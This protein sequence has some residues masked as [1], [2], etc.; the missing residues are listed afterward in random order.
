MSDRVNKQQIRKYFIVSTLLLVSC[1]GLGGFAIL[2]ASNFKQQMAQNA[3][4]KTTQKFQKIQFLVAFL[5][6]PN[7]YVRP[8]V[9]EGLSQILTK[10]DIPLLIP[11]L[12]DSDPLVYFGIMGILRRLLVREAIFIGGASLASLTLLVLLM[13]RYRVQGI[14]WAGYMNCCFPEEVVAELLALCEG[15][16]QAKKSPW[17][18]RIILLYQ[19]CTLIWA[20]YI[21][22][23]L[24]NLSLPPGHRGTDN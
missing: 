15:L 3:K 8:A 19:V 4:A 2:S 24:E 5:K 12:K 17:L 20:F 14:T 22:I 10:E 1:L 7:P 9:V 16:T 21:Q 13:Q 18:I 11:L 6:E 23:N